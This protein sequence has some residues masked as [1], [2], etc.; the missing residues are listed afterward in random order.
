MFVMLFAI[1]VVLAAG[2][3][4]AAH[5]LRFDEDRSFFP[6]L[7]IVIAGYYVLFAIIGEQGV[8][9]ELLIAT[10]FIAIA[11]TGAFWGLLGVGIGVLLHG[12]YDL[13]HPLTISNPGVPAWWPAFCAGF[14]V[15]LGAWVV[16]LSR[17]TSKNALHS[18]W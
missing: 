4:V 15:V 18:Q 17:K 1:G 12:V 13:V 14:D 7:L 3:L 5:W 2:L 8:V 9:T 16:Y 6:T 11:T 10:A